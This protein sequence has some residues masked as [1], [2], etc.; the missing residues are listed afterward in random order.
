MHELLSR[1]IDDTV[2]SA[3]NA[4]YHEEDERREVNSTSLLKIYLSISRLSKCS[5]PDAQPFP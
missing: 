1:R 4:A 2:V 5:Q 3:G